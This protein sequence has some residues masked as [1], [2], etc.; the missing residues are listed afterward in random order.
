[1]D[2]KL[3]EM[4]EGVHEGEFIK[5]LINQLRIW[6]RVLCGRLAGVEARQIESSQ[7]CLR[8][9]EAGQCCRRDENSSSDHVSGVP[10]VR[11]VR[12][13]SARGSSASATLRRRSMKRTRS[14]SS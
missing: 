12:K 10:T 5:W 4:G 2:F 7:D 13:K 8:E 6:N 14:P 11:G 3:P 9:T 1:M